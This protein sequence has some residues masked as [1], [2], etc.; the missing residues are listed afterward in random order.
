MEIT[1]YKKSPLNNPFFHDFINIM[2][3]EEFDAFYKTYFQSWSDI[4]TMV[5]YMK[6]YKAVEYGYQQQYQEPINK[7]L[8]IFVL[9]RIVTTQE[10]RK[11]AMTIFNNLKE[12][13]DLTDKVF[14]C[15][16]LDFQALQNERIILDKPTKQIT[17]TQ[18]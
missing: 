9:H 2:Q 13:D 10:L 17:Y 8:M 4:Q 16:L 11:E 6:L 3:N 14:F 15:R 18:N 1:S 12:T 5:F 7:E